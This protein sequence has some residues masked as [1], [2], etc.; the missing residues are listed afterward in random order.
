[1]RADLEAQSPP[2]SCAT[3]LTGRWKIPRH[4]NQA[5]GLRWPALATPLR[6]REG[7]P[8]P[9]SQPKLAPP[10]VALTSPYPLQY[11][12]PYSNRK[13]KPPRHPA[14]R[15]KREDDAFWRE[16][17]WAVRI[18]SAFPQPKEKAP[19]PWGAI[20]RPSLGLSILVQAQSGRP[21]RACTMTLS[22]RPGVSR[23]SYRLPPCGLFVGGLPP[24]KETGTYAS[25]VEQ[26]QLPAR[27]L[28]VQGQALLA[29]PIVA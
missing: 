3:T 8:C 12:R 28:L 4:N 16:G 23:Q 14:L 17:S 11:L 19:H 21:W 22:P 27:A 10:T 26:R 13:G 5:V 1:L 29:G 25:L 18:C 2:I 24:P 9:Q 6:T 15:G 20:T 7:R